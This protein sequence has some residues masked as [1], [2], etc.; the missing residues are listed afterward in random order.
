MRISDWSSDVCSSDLALVRRAAGWSK[1]T[2]EC[3]AVALDL[4]AQT[5]TVNGVNVDLTSYEYK[6]REYLMMHAGELVSKADLTEHIS[7]QDSDRDSNVLEVF[8]GLLRTNLDPEVRHKPLQTAEHTIGKNGV[9]AVR[10]R[11]EPD[12]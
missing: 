8:H 1:P 4:A 10:N 9:R 2:L 3:G 5:V 12:N 7:Q 11:W 6:V